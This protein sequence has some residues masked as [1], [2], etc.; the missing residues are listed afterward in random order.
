MDETGS[1]RQ[2]IAP[3]TTCFAR[4][5]IYTSNIHRMSGWRGSLEQKLRAVDRCAG[6][7]LRRSA[8]RDHDLWIHAFHGCQKHSC[9]LFMALCS[10]KVLPFLWRS[11]SLFNTTVSFFLPKHILRGTMR[12][13]RWNR[14]R[15]CP[16]AH[17]GLT[18]SNLDLI[19]PWSG[20]V[21]V[22]WFDQS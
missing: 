20:N 6:G 14:A 4:L 22:S 7:T 3:S 17:T 19:T 11:P 13:L 12:F 16:M 10:Y 8:S 5:Q 9:N 15:W 21:W 2:K 18:T 1:F